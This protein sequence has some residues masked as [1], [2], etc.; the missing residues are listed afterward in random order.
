MESTGLQ[1]D[2]EIGWKDGLCLAQTWSDSRVKALSLICEDK[3]SCHT[4]EQTERT[5][6]YIYTTYTS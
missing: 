2:L 6:I 3:Q 5:D 1:C 4:A